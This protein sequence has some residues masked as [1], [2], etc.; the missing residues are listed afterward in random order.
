MDWLQEAKFYEN[1]SNDDSTKIGV[2]IVKDGKLLAIGI[3]SFPPGIVR[4]PER[5][6]RPHKYFYTEHAEADAIHTAARN[7]IALKGAALYMS[8]GPW[9]CATCARAI[10]NAGIV[11]V[12][13]EAKPFPGK[14][15]WAQDLLL[16][17]EML[18]EK[19][20]EI[21]TV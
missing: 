10:I 5:L 15:D 8:C 19:G 16:A 13:G 7:G 6:V 3:N 21:I 17:R 12:I 18:Q 9:P 2:V 11:M 14:G 20:V 4:K 1:L